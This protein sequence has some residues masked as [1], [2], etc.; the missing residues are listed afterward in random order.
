[1]SKK[2]KQYALYVGDEYVDQ[3]TAHELASTLG[4]SI[5]YVRYMCTPA[6]QR[7]LAKRKSTDGSKVVVAIDDEDDDDD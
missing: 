6:Y 2:L 5:E 4:V 7:K 3:G 1:M